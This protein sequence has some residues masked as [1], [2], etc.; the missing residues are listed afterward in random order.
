MFGIQVSNDPNWGGRG[1][2]LGC[3]AFNWTCNG[4]LFT[5]GVEYHDVYSIIL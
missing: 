5:L 1:T 3:G 2:D 4:L